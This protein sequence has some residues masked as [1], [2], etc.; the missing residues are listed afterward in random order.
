M[1]RLAVVDMGK[2]MGKDMGKDMGNCAR[3]G[4]IEN[5]DHHMV[6]GKVAGTLPDTASADQSGKNTVLTAC[7]NIL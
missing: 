2:N 5:M 4:G 1:V 3:S 6:V 7:T